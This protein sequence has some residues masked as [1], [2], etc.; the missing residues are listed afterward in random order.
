[1]P[2][3]GISMIGNSRSGTALL[4]CGGFY[5]EDD[6]LRR[7]FPLANLIYKHTYCYKITIL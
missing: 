1:M 3:N 6:L 7:G 2:E 5:P 4:Y